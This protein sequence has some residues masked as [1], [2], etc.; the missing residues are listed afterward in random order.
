MI[1]VNFDMYYEYCFGSPWVDFDF[2]SVMLRRASLSDF[3]TAKQRFRNVDGWCEFRKVLR[4]NWSNQTWLLPR[5]HRGRKPADGNGSSISIFEKDSAVGGSIRF[6]EGTKH[7]LALC[8][9]QFHW[10]QLYERSKLSRNFLKE[11]PRN[12]SQDWKAARSCLRRQNWFD[13]LWL[14]NWSVTLQIYQLNTWS[15][16]TYSIHIRSISIWRECGRID[17][18][19]RVFGGLLGC[20]SRSIRIS[21]H[22]DWSRVCWWLSKSHRVRLD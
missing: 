7:C 19:N 9:P 8:P 20:T 22:I 15:V 12:W 4:G 2:M 10:Y 6:L 16:T 18:R 11:R 17:K 13:F 1:D 14:W 5:N 21:S 3:G